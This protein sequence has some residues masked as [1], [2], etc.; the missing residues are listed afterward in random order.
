MQCPQPHYKIPLSI[1]VFRFR[2]ATSG[3]LTW[4][5]RQ[6]IKLKE[7][8]E[9]QLREERQP[10]ETRLISELRNV[11][12][13]HMRPT[14]SHRLDGYTS[15]TTAF[16][17][18]DEDFTIPLHINTAHKNVSASPGSPPTRTSSRKYVTNTSTIYSSTLQRKDGER[19][20]MAVKRAHEQNRKF[21]GAQVSQFFL[22]FFWR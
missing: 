9:L 13:R 19:P 18:D 7:R 5:Q 22:G 16:A 20:F 1:F 4:L 15:D 3:N 12:S 17:D 11:Q 10:H 2:Y 8:R 6:Q 21:D 14:A